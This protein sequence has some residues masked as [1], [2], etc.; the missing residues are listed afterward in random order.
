MDKESLMSCVCRRLVIGVIV[1]GSVIE[2]CSIQHDTDS[3][4]TEILEKSRG[5]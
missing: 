4:G 5:L 3:I 1:S 2:A